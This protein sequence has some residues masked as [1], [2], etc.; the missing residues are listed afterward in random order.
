MECYWKEF[1][2]A[3]SDRCL[4]LLNG[5]VGVGKTTSTRIIAQLMGMNN[6]Q[7]PSFAIHL[8][9]KN[10]Q[11]KTLDHVDLYRLKDDEDLESSGFWDLFYADDGLVVIEWA[12]RLNYEYLPIHWQRI[13]V[14]IETTEIEGQRR[15]KSRTL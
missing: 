11:G 10:I 6:A 2:A 8:A 5:E 13:E 4:I 15:I 3:I 1:L 7:S 9:Y 14:K 12:Q